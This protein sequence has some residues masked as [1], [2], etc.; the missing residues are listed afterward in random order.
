MTAAAP[1][2]TTETAA[3]AQPTIQL[4]QVEWQAVL[5]RLTLLEQLP[6]QLTEA[7]NQLKALQTETTAATTKCNQQL[8]EQVH[9]GIAR[10]NAVKDSCQQQVSALRSTQEVLSQRIRSKSMVVHGF[11]DTAAVSNTAALERMV[12]AKFDSVATGAS[13]SHPS[14]PSHALARQVL[15]TEQCWWN[16]PAVKPSIRHTHCPGDSGSK[17]STLLTN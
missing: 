6:A 17:V 15:A 11:L 13:M 16:T 8:K 4:T 5:A 3:D 7:Q 1:A 12:K 9:N 2:D 10:G 14:R